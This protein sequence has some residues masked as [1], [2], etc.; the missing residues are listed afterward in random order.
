M[1]HF[2][3]EDAVISVN[4]L[5]KKFCRNLRMSMIYGVR[6]LTKSTFGI[7]SNNSKLEK[8]E[9][10]AIKDISFELRKGEVL[11]I[12]GPNGSGKSTL[13]RLLSGIF[14]PDEGE[15]I[16]KGRVGALIALG[17]GF[18]PHMTG[19]EN[20]YLNGVILG[21]SHDEI[22]A[23]FDKIITFSEIGQFVD[24][25]VSTYSS[26]MRV[27]LG[28]AIAIQINPDVLIIDEVLAVGDVGF[29]AK[30]YNLIADIMRNTAVIFVSHSIPILE[31]YCD[32]LLLLKEGS[33]QCISDLSGQIT[34]S[35]VIQ[36]YY[37]CYQEESKVTFCEDGNRLESFE[38]LNK[39]YD[40]L[41]TI[42]H[43]SLLRLRVKAK[44]E[45]AVSSPIV[46]IAFV[47][48]EL[49]V[50]ASLKS[51]RGAIKNIKNSIECIADI[52]P[53]ILNTGDYKITLV[54]MDEQEHRHLIWYVAAWTI[55]VVGKSQN[56]GAAAIFFDACWS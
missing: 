29:R 53:F 3:A 18:H 32:R 15:V 50:I 1:N 44:I 39:N 5:S 42:E 6:D 34:K 37:Q 47:N 7:K 43:G 31:R 21:M 45:N 52:N 46:Q 33:T 17:A 14:T 35:D 13:L 49:Q 11:G 2:L 22:D 54:V 41:K 23:K 8:D 51:S 48:R 27:R 9:F 36:E 30:C 24:A 10:W 28:F 40:A 38:I 20:I 4:N 55:K 26:G 12:I 19:R 16:I 56:Y 25:P